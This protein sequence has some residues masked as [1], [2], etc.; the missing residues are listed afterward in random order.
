[1][2][3][4]VKRYS[5]E[6]KSQILQ[7]FYESGLSLKQYT[8]SH[9]VSECSLRRWMDQ[10]SGKRANRGTGQRYSPEEKREAVEQFM[11][12]GMTQKN[13]SDVW[14]LSYKSLSK[15]V[16]VYNFDGPK[17]LEPGKIHA[18]SGPKKKRGRK[19][20]STLVS[21]K[22]LQVKNDFPQMGLKKLTQNLSRFQGIKV[23]PNT[24]KKVLEEND[25]Y[26]PKVHERKR[27]AP[28]QIRRFERAHPMQMWQSDITS[29]NLTRSGEKVYLVIFMDDHSRYVC[30]WS[31]ALRQ[32]SDFVMNCLL[33][34]VQRFGLPEEVLTD[35]GR[36]YFSWRGK[37]QFQNLL[38]K[39]GIRHVVSRSH[40][41][42]TL[43]KCERFWKTVGIEFWD[44][45]NPID[46]QDA[47]DRFSHYVNHYNHFRPH[48]GLNGM[49]PADRFFGLESE[50][51]LR[52][53]E[54]FEQNELRLAINEPPRRPVFLVGQI[55]DQSLS[56]HGESGKLVVNTPCGNTH[57]FNYDEFGAKGR[58]GDGSNDEDDGKYFNPETAQESRS[59]ERAEGETITSS[60]PCEGPM[61]SSER[62][63]ER[64]CSEESYRDTGLLDWA[65]EQ[66]GSSEGTGSCTDSSLADGSTSTVGDV[67]R[68]I[69]ATESEEEYD[70]SR[71]RSQEIEKENCRVG[72]STR[73]PES[74]DLNS[75][76][77]AGL[78]TS[79]ASRGGEE[80]SD[81]EGSEEKC[82]KE[83][84]TAKE[85]SSK[86]DNSYWREEDE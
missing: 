73:N 3:R 35:Q 62:G 63:A 80:E 32:T 16:S 7:D 59:Q 4:K 5:A 36:Q 64:D 67:C 17:G 58:I 44:R 49:T 74:F 70:Q 11:K 53:E 9:S 68:A 81:Q 25:T 26:E 2:S 21:D 50:I 76:F 23:S 75:S 52:L 24:V 40:H 84:A 41:P 77:D 22:I 51:K 27:K 29:Y 8:D 28:P 37:S 31:L 86:W 61:G 85:S 69:E 20:L 83:N 18:K 78:Q 55:G 6:E 39:R 66:S 38:H 33:D 13:F 82:Q 60:N 14:G 57:E 12:S 54:T 46:L 15:W 42:Q 48:Q 43:G 79:T 47:I 30:A 72:E 65:Q 1:M 34:G 10:K 19:R 56:M 45:A 71:G